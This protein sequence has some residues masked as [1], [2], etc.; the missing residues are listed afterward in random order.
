MFVCLL[1]CLTSVIAM[2]NWAYIRLW[3]CTYQ[4]LCLYGL[5]CVRCCLR[6]KFVLQRRYFRMQK[7]RM[8]VSGKT[9]GNHPYTQMVGRMEADK[10]IV[11][12][13]NMNMI[14]SESAHIDNWI[15]VVN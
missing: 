15:L 6:F 4:D 9:S 7:L 5:L 12:N 11:M 3:V 10:R 2:H 1:C 14:W 13:T 8:S